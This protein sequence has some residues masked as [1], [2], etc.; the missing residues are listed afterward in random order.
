MQ[1]AFYFCN[2]HVSIACSG[3]YLYLSLGILELELFI[4]HVLYT[5][6][7]GGCDSVSCP[8]PD[9]NDY[10]NNRTR[11]THITAVDAYRNKMRTSMLAAGQEPSEIPEHFDTRHGKRRFLNRPSRRL[12]SNTPSAAQLSAEEVEG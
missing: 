6:G 5:G 4:V 12:G 9:S 11:L 3:Q 7:R 8:T 1:G 2:D 10:T